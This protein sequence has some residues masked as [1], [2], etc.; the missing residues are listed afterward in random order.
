MKFVSMPTAKHEAHS[1][2]PIKEMQP[3]SSEDGNDSLVAL[4][5]DDELN[6]R[7]NRVI[8]L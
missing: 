1:G 7:V 4:F 5:V 8:I 3:F 6:F 2:N